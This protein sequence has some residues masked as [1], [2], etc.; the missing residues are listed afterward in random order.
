M[1]RLCQF[2]LVC[3]ALA[4]SLSAQGTGAGAEARRIAGERAEVVEGLRGLLDEA[5]TLRSDWC[6]S[7]RAAASGSQ[8]LYALGTR[9]TRDDSLRVALG[10]VALA[11]ARISGVAPPQLDQPGFT[12]TCAGDI[13]AALIRIED[14]SLGDYIGAAGVLKR[15]V[16]VG[17][18]EAQVSGQSASTLPYVASVGLRGWSATSPVSRERVDLYLSTNLL[19]EGLGALL[20]ALGASALGGELKNRVAVDLSFP[21]VGSGGTGVVSGAAISLFSF[22]A[23]ARWT[24]SG[25]LQS[26]NLSFSDSAT[27]R[28]AGDTATASYTA[29]GLR[30]EAF[31]PTRHR[32]GDTNTNVVVALDI[33]FPSYSPKSTGEV[34]KNAVLAD[35]PQFRGWDSWRL[36]ISVG[37]WF[38]KDVK[39]PPDSD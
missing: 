13:Q 33:L 8:D 17:G 38:W 3:A 11:A 14:A 6:V 5:N 30:L 23:G 27:V 12:P 2:V 37:L 34:L 29:P 18:R 32:V 1:R 26:T 31:S 21:V 35:F 15:A 20:G 36:G 22:T 19:G 16:R 24:A 7:G 28:L 25:L 39:P 10:E 4:G 9:T